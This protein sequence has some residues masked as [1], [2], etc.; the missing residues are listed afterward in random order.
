VSE[1]T[2]DL[3]DRLVARFP[4]LRAAF[5]GHLAANFGEVLPHVFMYDVALYAKHLVVAS[6]D[7]T[8]LDRASS[9]NREVQE[10]FDF[11]EREFSTGNEEIQGLISVSFLE[12]LPTPGEPGGDLRSL[13][14]PN[15]S[16]EL[17][18]IDKP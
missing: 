17:R 2:I 7:S 6:T 8:D 13:L 18:M 15:L 10:I 14:G 1:E 4:G 5:D 9:S 16:A 11:F 12:S 3:I